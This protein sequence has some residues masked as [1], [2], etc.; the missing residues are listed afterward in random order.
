MQ[1]KPIEEDKPP[2][3]RSWRMLY[4]VVIGALIFQIAVFYAI[5]SYFE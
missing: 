3:F 4:G 1:Q 5:T 2:V